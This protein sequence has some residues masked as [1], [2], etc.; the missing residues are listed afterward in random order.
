MANGRAAETGKLDGAP[1]RPTIDSA[2]ILAE[3]KPKLVNVHHAGTDATTT[4][5]G[6][7]TRRRCF[8]TGCSSRW[9]QMGLESHLEA[10]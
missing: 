5:T 10:R 8:S 7:T 9:H 4:A 1:G 2:A 6:S 3:I